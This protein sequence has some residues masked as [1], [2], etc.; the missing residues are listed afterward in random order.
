MSEMTTEDY[1][2]VIRRLQAD[3]ATAR[4]EATSEQ[5]SRCDLEA[6]LQTATGISVEDGLRE[7]V[8]ELIGQRNDARA[9]LATATSLAKTLTEERDALDAALR[10]PCPDCG[11]TDA[12]AELAAE[13]ALSAAL[14]DELNSTRTAHAA[15]VAERDALKATIAAAHKCW[16]DVKTEYKDNIEMCD[17]AGCSGGACE[18]ERALEVKP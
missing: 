7:A 14:Q 12:Q 1:R 6:D 10:K 16:Q 13:T 5:S 18:L 11:D 4:R 3:L 15:T 17:W 8:F 2:E 9:E